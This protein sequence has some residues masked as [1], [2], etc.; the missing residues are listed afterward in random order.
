MKVSAQIRCQRD[1]E[2]CVVADPKRRSVE[3]ELAERAHERRTRRKEPAQPRV[4]VIGRV[5]ENNL[6][7]N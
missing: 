7:S 6:R 5:H 1:V 2:H 3:I 4:L